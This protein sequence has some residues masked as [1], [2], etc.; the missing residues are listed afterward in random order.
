MAGSTQEMA[1]AYLRRDPGSGVLYEV[2]ATHL[3]TFLAR[4]IDDTHTEGLPGHVVR[5]LRAHLACGILAHGFARFF[6]FECGTDVLVAFSCK[7]R[8]FCPSCGGRRMAESAAHLVDHVF[9]RVP[10]RQWVI[11]FPWVVVDEAAT[12]A[13]LGDR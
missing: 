10:I 1:R 12:I 8:G 4:G 7:G 11:S 9:P 3:E 13:A 2:L 6:C 5:E